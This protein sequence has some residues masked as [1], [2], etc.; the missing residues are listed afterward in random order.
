MET[1]DR[2]TDCLPVNHELTTASHYSHVLVFHSSAP[3]ISPVKFNFPENYFKDPRV[4]RE[5]N[6]IYTLISGTGF[7]VEIINSN[8]RLI[9]DYFQLIANQ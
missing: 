2:I 1:Y 4:S 5:T 7:S 8:L 6:A 3:V 9:T